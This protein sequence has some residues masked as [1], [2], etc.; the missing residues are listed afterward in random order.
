MKESLRQGRA[1][2]QTCFYLNRQFVTTQSAENLKSFFLRIIK[3]M[4]IPT[5]NSVRGVSFYNRKQKISKHASRFYSSSQSFD[6]KRAKMV[7]W[8]EF[9]VDGTRKLRFLPNS[10]ET[11]LPLLRALHLIA[12]WRTWCL[13]P[14]LV[15]SHKASMEAFLSS[16]ST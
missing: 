3:L 13:D 7:T 15:V 8:W 10:V 9:T 12:L 2:Y 11:T 4:D 5:L 1:I 14:T 16:V 6:F